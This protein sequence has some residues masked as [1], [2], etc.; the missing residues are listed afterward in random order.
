[1]TVDGKTLSGHLIAYRGITPGCT[2]RSHATFDCVAGRADT[3][4]CYKQNG[5]STHK[6][7]AEAPHL[8]FF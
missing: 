6:W 2:E 8:R 7:G 1:M 4:N 5:I 3:V